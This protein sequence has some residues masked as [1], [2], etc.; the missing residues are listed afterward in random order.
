MGRHLTKRDGFWHYARRVPT[1]FTELDPRGVVKQST[2]IRVADDPRG[3]KAQVAADRIDRETVSYW[4]GL[5]DGR[6][7]EARIRYEAAR[8][9]AR[10]M[11]FDYA[12]AD[13]LADRSVAEILT[14]LERLMGTKEGDD[15]TARAA[16]LGT[17]PKPEIK[18]SELFAE[19]EKLQQASLRNK[20]EDQRRK[21]RNP[22]LRA[23]ANLLLVLGDDKSLRQMTR[24]DALDFRAWWQ[25]RILDEELAIDTANKDVGH[26]NKMW[27]TVDEAMRLGLPPIFARLRIEGGETG[28]RAAYTADFIQNSILA[29]GTLAGLNDEA[30]RTVYAMVETGLRPSEMVNLTERT[31]RLDAP[32]P[33]VSVEEDERETKTKDSIRQI[34][35]VGVSLM[36][37]QAQPNGFPRYRDNAASL[38]ALVNK[39]LRNHDLRPTLDHTMYSLRHGF[40]DRL[41]AVETPEKLIAAM[42]GHKYSRPKYGAGPSLEQKQKWLQRIALTPPSV[43]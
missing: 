17:E 28:Q 11:G 38:S 20:S 42:M 25:E 13:E 32:V 19:F 34:P 9:R 36:A 37:F 7:A 30:R 3:I 27:T 5:V 40:E 15:P 6:S 41:T 31:I 18:A 24:N 10:Y 16:V 1:A 21:W 33:Y 35:L 12:P 29:P 26:L 4:R 2:G 8:K 14:R 39:Y 22:K 23:M 43:V